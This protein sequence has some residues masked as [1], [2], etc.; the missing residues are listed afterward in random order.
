MLEALF[1]SGR[2]SRRQL[3][4]GLAACGLSA[5]AIE[6]LAGH[7]YAQA[8]EAAAPPAR[9]LC[10]IIL[11][12]FRPDYLQLA[13]MPE[14]HALAHRGVSYDRAWVGQL[15]SETPSGHAT[16]STGS[17]PRHDGVIGFEWRDPVTRREVLDGWEQGE[18]LGQ[19]GRDIAHSHA[20]SIPRV[21]KEAEPS[22]RVVTVSSEKVYAADAMGAKSA[23][24]VLYHRYAGRRLVPSGLPGQ[25]PPADFFHGRHMTLDLPLRHFTDWDYL[26][27]ELALNAFHSYR[28]RALMVNLPGSDVYG[29]Q[30]A[31]PYSPGVMAR[32]VAGQDR[33]IGRIVRAYQRAGIENQTLFVVTA[34]HGMVPNDRAVTPSQVLRAVQDA[35][36]HY[37]FHTGGTAKYIYLQDR[38]RS[39]SRAVAASMA[40]VPGVVGGYF[41]STSGGY[42]PAGRSLNHELDAAYRYLLSTFI[43]STAPEVVSPYREN[44]IGTGWTVAFGNHGGMSWGVQHVPLV[45]AG[46]GVRR[47][48]HSSA[49]ARLVDVAPTILNLLGHGASQLDGIPLADALQ[50]ATAHQVAAQLSL[51]TALRAHQDA[52]MAQSSAERKADRKAGIHPPPRRPFR[53]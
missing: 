4:G 51:D 28:P 53:P 16:I 23:D 46:P 6:L 39:R 13:P 9:Y 17:L 7:D 36:A 47:G 24:Y 3:L 18:M 35:G 52:L 15:E 50:S 2:I 33:A 26:S 1:A 10:L 48:V 31:G 40:R 34:D 14:F 43:G 49:P 41:R 29:H 42:E 45:L 19:V 32:V 25:I 8:L 22:A 11:D 12:G 38:F 30:F 20:T 5:S 27:T 44:T 37:L 21:I